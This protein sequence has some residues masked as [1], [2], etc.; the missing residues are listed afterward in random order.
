MV[1][2][3]GPVD[4]SEACPV[5]RAWDLHDNLDSR[6]AILFR[7]FASRALGAVPVAGTPGLFTTQ[8]DST[9]PV[10][11][12]RGL[13]IANPAVEQSFADAVSDLRN[14]GIPLDAPLRDWQY[15]RRGSEKIPIHGGPGSVGRVQRDQR[16]AGP[17]RRER[18]LHAT[19]RT[20]RAS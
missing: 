16:R 7:R 9:D 3:S 5:L 11:T 20:A 18:G 8:F 2:S 13:N 17:L 19:C 6:G 15:E 10:H 4:V 14:A 1:G 12:P